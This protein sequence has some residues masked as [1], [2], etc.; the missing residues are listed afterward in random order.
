[1]KKVHEQKDKK[2]ST[3]HADEEKAIS[4]HLITLKWLAAA[5]FAMRDRSPSAVTSTAQVPVGSSATSMYCTFTPRST[6][7]DRES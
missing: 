3:K 5:R 4:T 1:M 6:T 2:V 7:I